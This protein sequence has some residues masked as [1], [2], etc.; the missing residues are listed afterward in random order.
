MKVKFI[1][2]LLPLLV[3]AVSCQKSLDGELRAYEANIKKLDALSSKYPSLRIA[4]ET[5][6]K[7]ATIQYET[8]KKLSEEKS[9][10]EGISA[11]NK[12]ARP[13]FVNNIDE[14]EKL[15][16]SLP[17]KFSEATQKAFDE[18]DKEAVKIAIRTTEDDIFDA[19]ARL[20][21]ARISSSNEANSV[22]DEILSL[23]ENAENRLDK[24]IE[25][26]DAKREDQKKSEA[27]KDSQKAADSKPVK[28]GHCGKV[29]D[30]GSNS[31]KSCG[32]PLS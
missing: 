10:I 22:T 23:L 4:V 13:K 8:A 5:V 32:A 9:K 26:A 31:C 28:C 19:K 29:C 16:I 20:Q 15:V 14:I 11:A 1:F 24:V 25:S 21:N 27:K 7:D 12:I 18:N 3:T 6:K 17:N 30:P 2:Y